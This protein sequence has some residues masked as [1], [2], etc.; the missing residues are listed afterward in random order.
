MTT[1]RKLNVMQ[2]EIEHKKSPKQRPLSKA[3]N[4]NL[5]AYQNVIYTY[6]KP[7]VTLFQWLGLKKARR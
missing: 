3:T 2:T 4:E 7:K 6:R 1:E 5:I